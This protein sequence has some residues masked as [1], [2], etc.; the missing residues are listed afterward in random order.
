MKEG[1]SVRQYNKVFN[2]LPEAAIILDE[3]YRIADA[4]KA[5]LLLTGYDLVQLKGKNL[6]EFILS[7]SDRYLGVIHGQ[8]QEK[9]QVTIQTTN[10]SLDVSFSALEVQ[11]SDHTCIL[12]SI[13]SLQKANALGKTLDYRLRIEAMIASISARFMNVSHLEFDETVNQTLANIGDMVE[14]NRCYVYTWQNEDFVNTHEWVSPGFSPIMEVQNAEDSNSFRWIHDRLR[15]N[16]IVEIPALN[17]LSGWQD[18]LKARLEFQGI[19]STLA[20]PIMSGANGLIG[21][22]GFDD[23]ESEKRWDEEDIGLLRVIGEV[24]ANAFDRMDYERNL[25]EINSRL[26]KLTSQQERLIE[27]RTKSLTSVN[28]R[29]VSAVKELDLFVYRAA[30]DLKG[31]IK[32]LLGLAEVAKHECEE[33]KSKEYLDLFEKTAKEMDRELS[34]LLTVNEISSHIPEFT[35][36]LLGDFLE[37]IVE[38]IQKELSDRSANVTVDTT[39]FTIVTSP[40]LLKIILHNI[41][42]NALFFCTLHRKTGN[43]SIKYRETARAVE[44]TI[45]DNG[46]GIDPKI[47]P[48]IRDMFYRGSNDSIGNGLGLYLA[49]KA[50][51]KLFGTMLIESEPGEFT[52]VRIY[53]PK[54]DN[55]ITT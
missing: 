22:L 47:M 25:H 30:H 55:T 35:N 14:V 52:I 27:E 5:V 1:L 38:N 16:E 41:I 19:R 43:V 23:F 13:E 3:S 31:P 9:V 26:I 15:E 6:N 46:I 45:T 53:L 17:M 51:S 54:V 40:Y 49:E 37:K 8:S 39:A 18:E 50:L 10:G 28:E 36:L 21:F 32:R 29:L 20:V 34:K 4:N 33:L 48:R 7:S 11:L 2:F 44:I 12:C 42:E 24:L